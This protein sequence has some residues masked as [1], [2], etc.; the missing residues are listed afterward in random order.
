MKARVVAPSELLDQNSLFSEAIPQI[1]WTADAD[2]ALDFY[3]AR[4]FEYTGHPPE[5]TLGWGWQRVTHP[6]DVGAVSE[7]WNAALASGQPYE[8][9]C[10]FRN[11]EGAYRWFLGRALPVRNA[12]GTIRK[13]IGTSTDVHDQRR[14]KEALEFLAQAGKVL[15]ESLDPDVLMAKLAQLTIP[16]LADYCQIV[17][18]EED[19][20]R[21]LVIAH[22]DPGKVALL[23]EIHAR[24]PLTPDQPGIAHLL[25]AG[26]PSIIPE[27]TP[28]LRKLD[29]MDA[30]HRALLE[31]LNARSTLLIPLTA[32]GKTFGI[33]SLVYSDSYRRYAA[34]D[35]LLAQELGR[36]ASVALDNA[37]TFAREHIVAET[38]QRAMLPQM[39][40]QPVGAAFSCAYIPGAHELS[41]GGDWY[42]AFVMRDGRIGI[43]IGDVAGHGLAAAVIMG[44]IRQALRSAALGHEDPSRVLDH[45]S[46]LLE[47]HHPDAIATAGFGIFDPGDHSFIYS[48]AGHPAPLVCLANGETFEFGAGGLPLGMRDGVSAAARS[49]RI[50]AGTLIVLYTDGLLEF[51]RDLEEGER[52]LHAAAAAEVRNRSHNP[53]MTIYERVVKNPTHTDDIAILTISLPA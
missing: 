21:P 44:E 43:S 33:M 10:R 8:A 37:R 25:R 35:L 50:A 49:V 5:C 18:Q 7:C 42:D 31:R 4:W 29:S 14:A 6:D 52:L 19:R 12:D 2:G 39:L 23:E 20:F 47:L 24:Y 28:E 11:R 40:P 1:V 32:R 9:E 51:N 22:V 53:A 38:L 15:S 3:N 48:S 17:V 30:R 45:A 46:W 34:S 36:Q 26:E 13:W 27:I 41:V 16:E